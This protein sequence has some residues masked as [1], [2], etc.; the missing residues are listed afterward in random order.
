[1]S[2]REPDA[3]L[4]LR[5]Y[6]Q[7]GQF[8][9]ALT[10]SPAPQGTAVEAERPCRVWDHHTPLSRFRDLTYTQVTGRRASLWEDYVNT[11]WK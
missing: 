11:F 7:E 5:P 2:Y 4:S 10:A 3:A 6:L 8:P 1:M 9:E